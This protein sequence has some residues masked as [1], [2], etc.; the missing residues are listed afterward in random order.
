MVLSHIITCSAWASGNNRSEKK[1]SG[2]Y[3]IVVFNEFFLFLTI[4]HHQY[5]LDETFLIF[6][7]TTIAVKTINFIYPFSN[8]KTSNLIEFVDSYHL[9]PRSTIDHIGW[10]VWW[11]RFSPVHMT[12]KLAVASDCIVRIVKN[13]VCNMAV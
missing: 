8:L 1:Q 9:P 5:I 4:I 2:K 11:Q 3:Y 13:F 7:S 6:D 10:P 12:N